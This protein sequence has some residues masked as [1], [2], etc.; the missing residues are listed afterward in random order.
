MLRNRAWACVFMTALLLAGASP[1]L[2][3]AK[4]G[5][6]LMGGFASHSASGTGT[7]GPLTGLPINYTSSGLSIGIDYQIALGEKFSINPFL[8]LSSESTGGDL[9]SGT[10]AGH[11]ILGLELRFWP[12]DFFIGVHAGNY[13][14]VLTPPSNA[15]N[16][17]SISGSGGGSGVSLG[18]ESP[19]GHVF[20][21]GQFDSFKISYSDADIKETAARLQVG[22]RWK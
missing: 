11:G 9:T 1:A 5:F 12:G 22:Y 15:T 3:G 21:V 13:N 16:N 20:V 10:T 2:A 18:W 7:A 4:S 6:G 8:M 17:S 14:E 19:T